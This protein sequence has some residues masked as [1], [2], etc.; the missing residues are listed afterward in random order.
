MN[1][2]MEFSCEECH[3]H[4]TVTAPIVLGTNRID[5]ICSYCGA[6]Y[7]ILLCILSFE[8]FAIGKDVELRR[9]L[10]VLS[11]GQYSPKEALQ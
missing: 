3:K 9:T 11:D 10:G 5:T 4:T 7:H 1:I 6:Y 8:P 2:A